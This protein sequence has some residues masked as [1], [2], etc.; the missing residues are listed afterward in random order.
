[1]LMTIAQSGDARPPELVAAL[2]EAQAAR[3]SLRVGMQAKSNLIPTLNTAIQTVVDAVDQLSQPNIE[4]LVMALT[5]SMVS[6]PATT[7]TPMGGDLVSEAIMKRAE[8]MV[9]GSDDAE[10]DAEAEADADADADADAETEARESTDA[11]SGPSDEQKEEIENTQD[12]LMTM[13]PARTALFL[14][15]MSARVAAERPQA[16]AEAVARI[17]GCVAVFGQSQPR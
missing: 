8:E 2:T 14:N 11:K 16:D 6:M 1:M 7:P 5:Q 4:N 13:L 10:A 9:M 17:T 12:K 15:L 3:Q